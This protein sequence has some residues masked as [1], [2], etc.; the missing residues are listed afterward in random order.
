[1]Q[2]NTD[3]FLVENVFCRYGIICLA[4]HGLQRSS[5]AEHSSHC[6]WQ[7]MALWGLDLVERKDSNRDE[8]IYARKIRAVNGFKK[9]CITCSDSE[10]TIGC[11]GRFWKMKIA[12]TAP[13]VARP[14]GTKNLPALTEVMCH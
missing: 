1:M 5:G 11:H 4:G 3:D 7:P 13:R 12:E 2:G 14:N 10:T 9:E 6:P 8:N